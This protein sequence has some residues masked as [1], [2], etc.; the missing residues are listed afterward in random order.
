MSAEDNFQREAWVCVWGGRGGMCVP[1]WFC[2]I[3]VF[4]IGL[5]EIT[6]SESVCVCYVALDCVD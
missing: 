2:L 5:S 6:L 4:S 3:R 1:I